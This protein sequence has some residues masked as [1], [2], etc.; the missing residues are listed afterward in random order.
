M[1]RYHC[2]S[3]VLRTAEKFIPHDNS[4][5]DMMLPVKEVQSVVLGCM[6]QCGGDMI[7]V[8]VTM[9]Q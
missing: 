6:V 4:G 8:V 3:Y 9:L 2:H 5:N 1:S 7:P